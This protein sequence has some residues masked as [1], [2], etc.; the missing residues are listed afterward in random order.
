MT[1]LQAERRRVGR[2]VQHP[3]GG[4]QQR[5]QHAQQLAGRQPSA[6]GFAPLGWPT[7]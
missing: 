7:S 5:V 2:I 1:Q 6:W 3:H 4:Q